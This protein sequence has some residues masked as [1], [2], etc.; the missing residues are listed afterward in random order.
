MLVAA[1]TTLHSS[2]VRPCL[3]YCQ[4]QCWTFRLLHELRS[5]F[6]NI[7]PKVVTVSI[8][9]TA[10]WLIYDNIT[11]VVRV[12]PACVYTHVV[13]T[14]RCEISAVNTVSAYNHKP[15]QFVLTCRTFVM[16]NNARQVVRKFDNILAVSMQCMSV[17][18]RQ[19]D[20]KECCS[21]HR[22]CML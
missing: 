3:L 12:Q 22:G 8:W 14:M 7:L 4:Q 5:F 19:T 15:R 17:T 11:T 2:V 16:R 6:C 21:M 20:R 13:W 9:C 10:A 1:Q 18:D